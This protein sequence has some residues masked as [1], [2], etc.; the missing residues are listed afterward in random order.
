MPKRWRSLSQYLAVLVAVAVATA[1]TATTHSIAAEE[2]AKPKVLT[3]FTIIADMAQ[4]VAG[5]TMEIE[6]I[7]RP[8]AEVH[9][10]EPTPGDIVKAQSADLLLLN[11]LGLERWFERFYSQ[12]TDIPA[13]V[14]TEGITSIPVTEGD[15]TGQPNPHT[16]MSPKNA[17]V[18]V[19][20]IR[21]ALVT[22]SPEN[23][24]II[25]ANAVAY[26]A[27]IMAVDQKLE[28]GLDR[29]P[30]NERAL[31]TCEGAFAYLAR[32]YDLQEFYLWAINSENEGTPRQVATVIKSVTAND[33]PAVFCESTVSTSAMERV[34]IET[35]ARFGGVLYVDSL[36]GTDGPAP[37]YLDL[38]TTDVVTIVTGLT[39]DAPPKAGKP[40]DN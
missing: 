13:V 33:I 39:G 38:L 34:A 6:S 17:I 19:E 11:G 14:L 9:D 40:S 15:Y 2:R 22:L 10:Y 24:T 21:Q 37:T 32:D 12:I 26:S 18:Y 35:G 28:E 31:V 36:T 23:E 5:D 4:N 27:Q 1:I 3:T 8:G 30:D 29:L 20:N 7:T 16:W 25:N